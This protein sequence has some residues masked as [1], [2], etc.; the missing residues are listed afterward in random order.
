MGVKTSMLMRS[1]HAFLLGRRR[2]RRRRYSILTS[3]PNPHHE[4]VYM[5]VV[6]FWFFYVGEQKGK[7]KSIFCSL[8]L[9]IFR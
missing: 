8:L 9:G 2:R 1:G 7:R 3:C 6:C 4:N 5:I